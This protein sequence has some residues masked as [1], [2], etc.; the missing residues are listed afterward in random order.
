MK[1]IL[2]SKK[3]IKM[4]WHFALKVLKVISGKVHFIL[5]TYPIF[6]NRRE[7]YVIKN[8]CGSNM[9]LYLRDKGISR[10]LYAFG[11]RENY[12]TDLI[13]K[14][15]LINPNQIVLDIGAN[16]GY[17]A[18]MEAKTV[19]PNGK[20][21]AVEPVPKNFKVLKENVEMN[22]LNNVELFNIA[23]GDKD[24]ITK[25]HVSTKSNWS[26]IAKKNIP[27]KIEETI[28]VEMTTV[29]KFIKNKKVP[30]FIRMDVEGYEVNILKGMQKLIKQKNLDIF[31]EF[32][33]QLISIADIKYFFENLEGNQFQIKYY[34]MNPHL[35]QNPLTEFSYVHLN[36]S[37][38]YY[39]K[40]FKTLDYS[41]VLKMVSTYDFKRMPHFLFHKGD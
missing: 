24:C 9:R 26:R 34:F 35:F 13:L 6:L 5:V 39:G 18:L 32:H 19:G 28:S 4:S 17:Y 37:D 10:E 15:R 21:Y 3:F 27:D 41:T 8:I 38:S 12:S 2:Q 14:D 30:T 33:P 23:L 7:E 31:V 25:M 29:D 36:Q 20:V 40:F 11:K 1:I 16:I 22:E